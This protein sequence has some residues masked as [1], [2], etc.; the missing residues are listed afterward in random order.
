[1]WPLKD[2]PSMSN[3]WSH[4][5]SHRGSTKWTWWVRKNRRAH[6]A[7]RE[8]RWWWRGRNWRGDN[9]RWLW[10]KQI[11]YVYNILKQLKNNLTL[12]NSITKCVVPLNLFCKFYV[13]F[14]YNPCPFVSGGHFPPQPPPHMINEMRLQPVLEVIPSSNAPQLLTTQWQLNG[15][16]GTKYPDV[17]WWA[18]GDYQPTPY[19][20]NL[21]KLEK[22]KTCV[23]SF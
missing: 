19:F 18:N 12:K 3:R 1:M 15:L 6:E 22:S 4:T 5:H 17:I 13:Y 16:Y 7:G 2:Y 11:R 21:G 9:E 10:S 23:T 14:R 8:N 20:P